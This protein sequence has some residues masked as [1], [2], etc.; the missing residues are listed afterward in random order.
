MEPFRPLIR[1]L[2]RLEL[3][4]METYLSPDAALFFVSLTKAKADAKANG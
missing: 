3:A 4:T 2:L 1:S